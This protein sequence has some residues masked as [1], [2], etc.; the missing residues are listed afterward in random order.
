M[1][2][3]KEIIVVAS[4]EYTEF[5]RKIS[6]EI[7]KLEGCNG[8]NWTI[9]QFEDNEFQL[10]GDRYAIFIGNSDENKLTKDF[11]PVISNLKNKAG[12][13]YGFDGTKAVAFGKGDLDQEK[14]FQKVLKE[15]TVLAAGGTIG[16][17]IMSTLFIMI[18]LL[19]SI[20]PG[21]FLFAYFNKKNRE[22]K[23]RKEQTKTALTFF[24]AE[25]FDKWVGI[26]KEE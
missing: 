8:A 11:L 15:A 12:V 16:A 6:H 22:K 5:A 23:L 19:W 4:E 20:M 10:G 24:M 21:Y 14:D 3:N 25:H 26:E 18:P 1:V 9:K 13:S 17:G 7:S 2:T